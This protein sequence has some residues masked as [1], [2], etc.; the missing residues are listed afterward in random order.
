MEKVAKKVDKLAHGL[1]W[2]PEF[3]HDQ[4][5]NQRAIEMVRS[6]EYLNKV[7]MIKAGNLQIKSME[8]IMDGIKIE[9][10][11]LGVKLTQGY[12]RKET[13]SLNMLLK[14]EF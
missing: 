6:D 1:N 10:P 9:L 3:L 12:L 11:Y 8:F 2:E 4:T 14:K 5:L 13:Q 7:K